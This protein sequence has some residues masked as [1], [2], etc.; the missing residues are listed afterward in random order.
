MGFKVRI[1][2]TPGVIIPRIVKSSA[3]N[4]RLRPAPPRT[5]RKR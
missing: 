5:Q 4:N 1:V 3:P 2:P